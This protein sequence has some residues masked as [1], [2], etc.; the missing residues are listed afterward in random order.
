MDGDGP[1]PAPRPELRAQEHE[2]GAN[3]S[4]VAEGFLDERPRDDPGARTKRR[5]LGS[6]DDDVN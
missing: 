5:D 2:L 4:D 3:A 6:D 1:R